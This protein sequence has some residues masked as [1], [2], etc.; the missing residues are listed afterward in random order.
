MPPSRPQTPPPLRSPRGIL[1]KS[2]SCYCSRIQRAMRARISH[3]G[4][5][6]SCM[7]LP[8]QRFLSQ[9]LT[10]TLLS[11]CFPTVRYG[12]HL[13]ANLLLPVRLLVRRSDESPLVVFAISMATL[14]SS[15]HF[16]ISARELECK[17]KQLH[18]DKIQ[19]NITIRSN[20][21]KLTLKESKTKNTTL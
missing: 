4:A 2:G 7:L 9:I 1:G 19:D 20:G 16:C 21:I 17:T 6:P 8:F 11:V 14:M 3:S 12:F 15:I 18:S 10:L 13:C 5:R